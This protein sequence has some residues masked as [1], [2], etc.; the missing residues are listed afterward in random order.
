MM[1]QV[2]MDV[3]PIP[4]EDAPKKR[5]K[6]HLREHHLRNAAQKHG[7]KLDQVMAIACYRAEEIRAADEQRDMSM[8]LALAAFEENPFRWATR[9]R[10]SKVE[11]GRFWT[12]R[13]SDG[14]K[15]K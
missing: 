7:A 9:A 1:D 3:D 12:W 10:Q 2:L 6:P 15:D 8:E 11:V 4:K 5:I 14:P 13:N